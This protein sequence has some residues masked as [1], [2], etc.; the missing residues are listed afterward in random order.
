MHGF[1]ELNSVITALTGG[2][3]VA[4]ILKVWSS[5]TKRIAR[6]Q[7]ARNKRLDHL[8]DNDIVHNRQLELQQAGIVAMLHHE[9]YTICNMHLA[10]GYIS[11]ADL[12][13]LGYL[14]RSYRDLGG[15][16]TGERLYAMVCALPIR[17]GD[18]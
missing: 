10:K 17:N 11:T 6:D 7:A 8:E 14:F 13:D 4:G 12:D 9:L 16:G 3:I 18:D 1:L 2:G 15:N 5:L